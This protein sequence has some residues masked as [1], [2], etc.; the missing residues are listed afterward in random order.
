MW[1]WETTLN[2]LTFNFTRGESEIGVG[3]QRT[4]LSD[5]L[6]GT[7]WTKKADMEKDKL[8]A[9]RNYLGSENR[10]SSVR[11]C[12]LAVNRVLIFLS[13]EHRNIL[14]RQITLVFLL[15]VVS[16]QTL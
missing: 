13:Y 12:H 8:S 11:V 2:P 14:A 4:Q 3:Y 16:K 7:K 9:S 15:R 5:F 6:A 1:P 10:F